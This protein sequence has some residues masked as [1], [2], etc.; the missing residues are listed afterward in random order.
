MIS[1]QAAADLV[2][3]VFEEEGLMIGGLVALHEP[4]DALVWSLMRN[5]DTIRKRALRRLADCAGGQGPQKRA[6]RPDPSPHPAVE[7]FLRQVREGARD[8]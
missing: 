6:D 4:D 5:L 8:D 3:G 1:K 2:A 7:A